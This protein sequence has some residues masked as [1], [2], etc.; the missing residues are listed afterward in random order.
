MLSLLLIGMLIL[1]FNI[2]PVKAS[3]TIYVGS[4]YTFTSNI[5][6][7]I[8]VTAD[9]IIIDGNGYILQGTG[10]GTG[11][12]LSYRSN[13]TIKNVNINGFVWGIYLWHSSNNTISGNQITCNIQG[14]RIESSSNNIVSGNDIVI[15]SIGVRF[16]D[17]SNNTISG[18]IIANVYFGIIL[19]PSCDNNTIFGNDVKS[20]RS[21]ITLLM[22]SNN[23]VYGNKITNSDR[24]IMIEES[25]SNIVSGNNITGNEIGI[26]L[27]VASNNTFYHNLISNTQQVY[28]YSWDHPPHSPSINAWDNGYPSGGNYWSDYAGVDVKSGVPIRISPIVTELVT[29]NM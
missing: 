20:D 8:V 25:P 27:I 28:D 22:S 5:F 19:S 12:D 4:D 11:I 29:Q 16:W 17:A 26:W 23:T 1:T 15:N 3:G 2:Q 21:G 7:S 13:V 18:N 10:S 24:G 6:E 14:V 9:N